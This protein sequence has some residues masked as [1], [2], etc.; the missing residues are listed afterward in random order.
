MISSEVMGK[1]RKKKDSSP[2]PIEN[3]FDFRLETQEKL[4][5]SRIASP[6]WRASAKSF[7]QQSSDFQLS[8]PNQNAGWVKTT[9]PEDIAAREMLDRS[10][11]FFLLEEAYTIVCQLCP[12]FS[13]TLDAVL[14]KLVLVD[15][16]K[17]VDTP[18]DYSYSP[19][20]GKHV[21]YGKKAKLGEIGTERYLDQNHSLRV[22]LL[23]HE[24]F[25]AI[26]VEKYGIDLDQKREHPNYT[27]AAVL[28]ESLALSLEVEATEKVF[29][30]SDSDKTTNAVLAEHD[31]WRSGALQ[32]INRKLRLEGKTGRQPVNPI[33][34]IKKL[35]R[36][37]FRFQK[38]EEVVTKV[39][40][41]HYLEGVRLARLLQRRGWTPKDAPALLRS[42]HQLLTD[43]Y[44]PNYREVI[45]NIPIDKAPHSEYQE[46]MVA[47]SRLEP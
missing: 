11:D 46:I 43:A 26:I 25:H 38:R 10:Y 18:T 7:F 13:K 17:P 42:I 27:L 8:K 6:R 22:L 21:I 45:A 4:F 39:E 29:R 35:L 20:N 47:I 24:L 5:R 14:D 30:N 19:E 2:D 36:R 34:Y 9:W 23:M 15:T 12:G 44:G 1:V 41:Q 16:K 3:V 33:E 37:S 28:H 31:E 40:N 32:L